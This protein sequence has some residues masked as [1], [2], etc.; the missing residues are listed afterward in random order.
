MA[1]RARIEYPGAIYHV[2]NRGN[3]RSDVFGTQGAAKSFLKTLEEAVERYGWELGAYVVMRNHYH[4]ALRTPAPNLAMGMHWLQTTFATR[5]NRLRG[6]RGHVFQGRYQAILL[7]NE[8]VWARVADYI[9]LNPVRAGVVPIDQ[10]NQF[11]GSSLTA[12]CAQSPCHWLSPERWLNT[13][14]LKHSSAGWQAYLAQ[15]SNEDE[16][17]REESC[18]L[19]S[20]GYAQGSSE[21]VA[22]TAEQLRESGAQSKKAEYQ[23]P[24]EAMHSVWEKRLL[25]LLSRAGRSESDMGKGKPRAAWKVAIGVQCQQELGVPIVWMAERMQMGRPSTVRVAFWRYLNC[26]K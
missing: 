15:L 17:M 11:R 2:I 26:N 6:E 25:E 19:F 12:F 21:W 10:A 1:R 23:E 16:L 18:G 3:Y 20:K 14:G 13:K 22:K 4:L 7:E 24:T 8:G 5:F 9:H